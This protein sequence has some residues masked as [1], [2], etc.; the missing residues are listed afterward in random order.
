MK[1]GDSKG[2][3]CTCFSLCH[4]HVPL[5]ANFPTLRLEAKAKEGVAGLFLTRTLPLEANETA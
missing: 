2:F 5:K 4:P 3:L 1:A